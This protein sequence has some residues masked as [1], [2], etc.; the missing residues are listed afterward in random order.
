MGI[1][2]WEPMEISKSGGVVLTV[3]LIFDDLF[4]VEGPFL[5]VDG[6]DL[7]LSALELTAHDLDGVALADGDG[8]DFVL[9]LQFL[10]QVAAH[11]LSPDVG[12]GRE[13]GLPGLSTLA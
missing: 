1:W 5:S 12:G 6:L 3:G 13:V 8:A 7:A 10:A 2:L 9:G 4:D 11:D